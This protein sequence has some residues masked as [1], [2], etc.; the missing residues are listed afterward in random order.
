[1]RFKK[2]SV[3]LFYSLGNDWILKM[4]S[5]DVFKFLIKTKLRSFFPTGKLRLIYTHRT[6]AAARQ[7]WTAVWIMRAGKAVT[8]DVSDAWILPKGNCTSTLPLMSK[9]P[10]SILWLLLSLPL[11]RK[12]SEAPLKLV[13]SQSWVWGAGLGCPVHSVSDSFPGVPPGSY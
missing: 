7:F 1:M 3:I 9:R 2:I 8:P 13:E 11:L 6:P 12:I 10:P 5:V 4:C